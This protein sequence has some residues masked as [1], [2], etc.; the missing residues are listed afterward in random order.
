MLGIF[1]LG[2]CTSRAS[3]SGA[4]F[5]GVIGALCMAATS[6]AKYTCRLPEGGQVGSSRCPVWL[7]QVGSLS[8]FLYATFGTAITLAVG[9]STSLL[10]W[11]N[12][13]EERAAQ[14]K[15]RYSCSSSK[16]AADGSSGTYLGTGEDTQQQAK[17]TR[18][19]PEQDVGLRT[20][21]LAATS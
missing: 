19:T 21:L 7:E 2:I 18:K 11:S 5:G 6:A 12:T 10:V 20:S 13:A 16:A 8:V 1:L 15:L 4:L 14:S 17:I 3:S 9:Y